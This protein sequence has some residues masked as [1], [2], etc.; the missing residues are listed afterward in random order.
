MESDNESNYELLDN[1]STLGSNEKA[2]QNTQQ[3]TVSQK[4]STASK[5]RQKTHQKI[6]LTKI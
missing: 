2:K 1:K 6:I 3:T 5:R 4:R